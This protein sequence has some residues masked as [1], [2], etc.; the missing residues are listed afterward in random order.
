MGW[1]VSFT[2]ASLPTAVLPCPSVGIF[3]TGSANELNSR[4]QELV[5]VGLT[6]EEQED[7]PL[8]LHFPRSGPFM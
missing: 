7:E 5:L 6:S 2:L 4:A 3:K 8:K 1:K